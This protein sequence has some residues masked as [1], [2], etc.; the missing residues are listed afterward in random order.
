M[1][2]HLRDRPPEPGRRGA[3]HGERAGGQGDAQAEGEKRGQDGGLR[4]SRRVCTAFRRDQ[5]GGGEQASELEKVFQDNKR[6]VG[7][8]M[9][10]ETTPAVVIRARS[11]VKHLVPGYKF[12]LQRHFNADGKY[13]LTSVKHA[14]T[15]G[16]GYRSGEEA[17]LTYENEATCI[18][19]AMPY[20]PR[21]TTPKPVVQGSQ[22]A[23]VVGPKGEEIFTDKYGRV[24][25]QFHWDRDG[26]YNEE[27]STWLRV[28]QLAA[29]RRWEH[30][31]G[32]GSGRR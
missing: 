6:T 20:R 18:P 29:G 19:S 2:P 23:V 17:A 1:G 28:G 26:K 22:T 10:E 16:A 32:R 14:A 27:S 13:L 4:L 3:D 12:T 24:K 11:N 5:Q 7:L 31:T 30:P 8:R 9:D 15:C 25:V 21:R